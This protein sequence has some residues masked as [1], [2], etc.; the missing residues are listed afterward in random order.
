MARKL[1]F[2]EKDVFERVIESANS[3]AVNIS[4]DKLLG[5]LLA[6]REAA[7]NLSPE[8]ALWFGEDVEALP[9]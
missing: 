8:L 9:R 4:G 6:K 2:E 1:D 3:T 5:N 7:L